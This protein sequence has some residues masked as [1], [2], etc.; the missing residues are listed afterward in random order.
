MIKYL[1]SILITSFLSCLVVA[2]PNKVTISGHV[3]DAGTGEDLI[4]VTVYV[5]N[6]SVGTISNAYGFY[7][8]T[9]PP[10]QYQ[11]SYSYVGYENIIK[12]IELK[13]NQVLNID[14][15]ESVQAMQEIVISG[16]AVDQNVEDLSM[17]SMKVDIQQV[18]KLPPLFGEADIIK[19]IQMMPGVLV[20]GEGSS[21]YFVR[22]GNVDHNLILLDEA[23]VYDP[24]HLFGLVSVF[25]SSVI[26]NSELMKGGIPAQYGGRLASILDVRTKDG[27]NKRLSGEAGV[28]LLSSKLVLEGPIQKNKSSFIVSG[29]R[30]YLDLFLPDDAILKPAFHDLNAKVNFNLNNRNTLYAAFYAGR[31]Q[32]KLLD[33]IFEWDWGNET[34]TLRWNHIFNDRL[35]SNTTLIYS[36]FDYENVQDLPGFGVNWQ[37]NLREFSLKQDLEYYLNPT[38]SLFFGFSSSYRT[39]RPGNFRPTDE[40]SIFNEI[41]LQKQYAWDNALYISNKHEVSPSLSLEYGVRF[42]MFSQIGKAT[43]YD[44]EQ[45]EDPVQKVNAA[46]LDTT[47]YDWGEVIKTFFNPEP[48]FSARLKVAPD[49]SLKL[50][51]NRMVQYVHQMVTGTSP[52]PIAVWQPSSTHIN[53]QK[54][55]QIA[56]GYFKNLQNNMYETSLEVYYKKMNDI[57]DF[58]DNAQVFFNEHLPLELAPGTSDS[59][60][61][62]FLVRKVKGPLTGWV[63]YTWSKTTREIP[64]VNNGVAF[65]AS[66]DRRHNLTV[67]GTYD[68]NKRYSLGANWVFG[69]GRGLTLPTGKYNFKG[70]VVD[71][72]T[73]RNEYRMPDF[74]RFDLSLSIYSKDKPGRW[75][76]SETNIS[77]YNM[78]GRRNPFIIFSQPQ[79][80]EEGNFVEFYDEEG[81]LR[82]SQEIVQVNLFGI[83]PSFSYIFKF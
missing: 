32:M 76:S 7:S 15:P 4:G 46:I 43:V 8:I 69:T 49:A 74:H 47:Y 33:N 70:Q 48:R 36:N 68:I 75:W 39:F 41:G 30:S 42:S 29:R 80:D 3:K 66:Y 61:A 52:L 13:E 83:L 23:P 1:F 11:L 60:G 79:T 38:N 37:A 9:L 26:K 59:Y 64:G 21:A 19:T 81:N 6:A 28:G 57:V 35:F 34:A 54:A 72:Y 2:Q 82:Q 22:G 50:S 14:L 12:E 44:Y 56:L 17:S 53:P 31:D 20:A 77:L 67:V 45:V 63:G 65:P 71:L 40:G 27:N 24:S 78:Y 73:G 62:E 16:E 10:G 51:Y 5:K 58:R 25:N 55:D 18:K